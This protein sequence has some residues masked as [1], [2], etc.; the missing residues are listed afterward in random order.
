MHFLLASFIAFGPMTGVFFENGVVKSNVTANAGDARFIPVSIV[1]VEAAGGTIDKRGCAR[2]TWTGSSLAVIPP[3]E[4]V[5]DPR[6]VLTAW[7]N[8]RL[9]KMLLDTAIADGDESSAPIR[10]ILLQME[11]Q[12]LAS[13]LANLARPGNN[14][15]EP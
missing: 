8:W 5:M 10:F 12:R 7:K 4:R 3:A 6:E 2:L 11:T 9:S 15:D 13:V 14:S 1:A